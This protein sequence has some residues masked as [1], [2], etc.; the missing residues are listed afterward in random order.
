MS[1]YLHDWG[2]ILIAEAVKMNGQSQ[3]E[4]DILRDL[5]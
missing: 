1:V 3:Q 2:F 5:K 4:I